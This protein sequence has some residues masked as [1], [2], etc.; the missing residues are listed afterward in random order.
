MVHLYHIIIRKFPHCYKGNLLLFQKFHIFVVLISPGKDHSVHFTIFDQTFQWFGIVS[1][2]GYHNNVIIISLCHLFH[3]IHTGMEE[4]HIHQRIHF[5]KD[6]CDIIGP[7]LCQALCRRIWIKAV[8]FD[9]IKDPI[10]RS[11]ADTP[12]P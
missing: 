9:I 3:S 7:G 4:R 11:R 6:D 2:R 8:F 12:F 10:P 5:R 1:V